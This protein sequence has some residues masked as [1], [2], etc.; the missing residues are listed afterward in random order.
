MR[1]AYKIILFLSTIVGFANAQHTCVLLVNTSIN[2]MDLITEIDTDSGDQRLASPGMYLGCDN[3]PNAGK[4]SI[5]LTYNID[6][7]L[8]DGSGNK[9]YNKLHV[10]KDTGSD[11]DG[12][13][14]TAYWY[15]ATFEVTGGDEKVDPISFTIYDPSITHRDILYVINY[16]FLT[17]YGGGNRIYVSLLE[18]KYENE[19]YN[20]LFKQSSPLGID[21]NKYACVQYNGSAKTCSYSFLFGVNYKNMD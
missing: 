17:Y 15:K 9:Y 5:R 12:N 19:F 16:Q 13:G 21:L 10:E 3:A 2:S 6:A 11:K 7:W 20:N 8:N 14:V 18:S 1:F 4:R